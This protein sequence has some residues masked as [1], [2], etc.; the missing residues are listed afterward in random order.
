M[1]KCWAWWRVNSSH[2]WGCVAPLH[3]NRQPLQKVKETHPPWRS[4]APRWVL[5]LWSSWEHRCVICH[6]SDLVQ[7]QEDSAWYLKSSRSPLSPP[8][9]LIGGSWSWIALMVSPEGALHYC[10]LAQ[11][12]QASFDHNELEPLPIIWTGTK[13]T[14]ANLLNPIT[15]PWTAILAMQLAVY[16]CEEVKIGNRS[17]TL[18]LVPMPCANASS[19]RLMYGSWL[20]DRQS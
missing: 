11:P 15:L 8:S 17:H 12:S 3:Y 18:R 19:K 9:W 14:L 2:H 5:A 16:G 13:F 4:H 6:H 1:G 10:V 20:S 7:V